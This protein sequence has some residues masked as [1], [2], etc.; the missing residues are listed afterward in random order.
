S[1]AGDQ[2]IVATYRNPV[3]VGGAGAV[4]DLF[5]ILDLDFSKLETTG[6]FTFKQDTDNDS[7]FAVPEPSMLALFG[8][9]LVGA[10]RARRRARA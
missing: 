9:G 5:H 2:D 7:R 3:G 6:N 4:G 8:L 10:A 1:L